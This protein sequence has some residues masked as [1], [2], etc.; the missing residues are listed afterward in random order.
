MSDLLCLRQTKVTDA[1]PTFPRFWEELNAEMACYSFPD[2]QSWFGDA[3]KPSLK[4][5]GSFRRRDMQERALDWPESAV[6][7]SEDTDVEA[8]QFAIFSSYLDTAIKELD[9]LP[10]CLIVR[11]NIR[12]LELSPAPKVV[13]L[14]SDSPFFPSGLPLA[15]PPQE[16]A[17]NDP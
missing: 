16:S 11:A 15:S 3:L 5:F 13:S 14:R 4:T 6:P 2:A 17:P 10:D 9:D 7:H 8:K 12:Q 1:H